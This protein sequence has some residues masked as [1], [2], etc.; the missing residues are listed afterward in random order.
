MSSHAESISFP[1]VGTEIVFIVI[2][3]NLPVFPMID[4]YFFLLLLHHPPVFSHICLKNRRKLK[5]AQPVRCVCYDTF[6]CGVTRRKS[7]AALQTFRPLF[8][9]S[10]GVKAGAG[11]I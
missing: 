11:M 3:V 9:G 8:S 2:P 5:K 4:L 7:R 1:C 6:R 10:M